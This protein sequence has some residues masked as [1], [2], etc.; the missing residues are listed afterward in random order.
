MKF[1]GI[2]YFSKQ[3]PPHRDAAPI[4]RRAFD[5]FGPDRMIW[6]GLGHTMDAYRQ[7]VETFETLLAF[8]SETDRAKIRGQTARN[9]FHI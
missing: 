9:F 7:A 4:V 1:S 8:A 5:A 3:K 2:E 6:G